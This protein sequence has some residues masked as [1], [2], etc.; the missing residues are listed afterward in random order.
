MQMPAWHETRDKGRRE[1][2]TA[3]ATG[4]FLSRSPHSLLPFFDV[5]TGLLTL[6]LSLSL[7]SLDF[8][9]CICRSFPVSRLCAAAA[10]ADV[11]APVYTYILFFKSA[12]AFTTFTHSTAQDSTGQHTHHDYP[13]FR[14]LP[15]SLALASLVAARLRRRLRCWWRLFFRSLFLIHALV[16]RVLSLSLSFSPLAPHPRSVSERES[17]RVSGTSRV[18]RAARGAKGHERRHELRCIGTRKRKRQHQTRKHA[19]TE[20]SGES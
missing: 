1:E 15:T 13:G 7:P 4:T 12:H 14:L 5:C 6:S 17:E 20:E 19:N 16:F 3:H 2:G 9:V 10:A 18:L 8:R 11:H